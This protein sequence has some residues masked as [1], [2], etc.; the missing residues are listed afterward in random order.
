MLSAMGS[1][2]FNRLCSIFIIVC[3]EFYFLAF[4]LVLH[5]IR[6]TFFMNIFLFLGRVPLASRIFDDLENTTS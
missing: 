2:I 6:I 4:H 1:C 3:F 5:F